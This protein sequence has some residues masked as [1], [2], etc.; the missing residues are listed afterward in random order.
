MTESFH[1]RCVNGMLNPVNFFEL[2][3]LSNSAPKYLNDHQKYAD[4][5]VERPKRIEL[6]MHEITDSTEY[7]LGEKDLKLFVSV[8]SHFGIE[9]AEQF[10]D[11][12]CVEY[13]GIVESDEFV[14]IVFNGNT[15]FFRRLCGVS[16]R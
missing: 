16:Q 11:A 2:P 13:E 5:C 3:H 10:I 8:L 12:F 7:I 15:Y 9:S 14:V 6:L 4:W 1:G